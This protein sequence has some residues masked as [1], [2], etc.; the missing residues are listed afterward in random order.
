MLLIRLSILG[1]CNQVNPTNWDIPKVTG[2]VFPVRQI[3]LA[4]NQIQGFGISSMES[5]PQY[6]A[7]KLKQHPLLARLS[8]FL[9]IYSHTYAYIIHSHTHTA[10]LCIQTLLYTPNHVHAY[11]WSCVPTYTCINT[12]V[13]IYTTQS[14]SKAANEQ[15][16]IF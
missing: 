7:P 8:N 6:F 4:P 14:L 10:H 2:C 13:H 12:H 15:G 16:L 11:L 3:L 5:D 1:I 9:Y